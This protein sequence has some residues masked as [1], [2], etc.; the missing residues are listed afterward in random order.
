VRLRWKRSHYQTG[1]RGQKKLASCS[2]PPL[3]IDALNTGCRNSNLHRENTHN[4]IAKSQESTTAE[5]SGDAWIHKW[6]HGEVGTMEEKTHKLW[7]Q[8]SSPAHMWGKMHLNPETKSIFEEI[9]QHA[10][11]CVLNTRIQKEEQVE[12]EEHI[13]QHDLCSLGLLLQEINKFGSREELAHRS[14]L[15][16]SP[17]LFIFLQ[18]RAHRCCGISLL[19]VLFFFFFKSSLT[20]VVVVSKP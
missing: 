13:L 12:E 5:N 14:L 11:Y 4:S 9:W 6:W 15:W 19:H 7:Q 18:E 8:G 2:S 1:K 10:S 16:P 17:Y 3:S 20:I